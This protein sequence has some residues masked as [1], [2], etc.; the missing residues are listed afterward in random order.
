MTKRRWGDP[1]PLLFVQSDAYKGATRL[2]LN[3][4][5]ASGLLVIGAV[6]VRPCLPAL[7][8]M[9]VS[10]LRTGACASPIDVGSSTQNPRFASPF[11]RAGGR[12]W[13]R[14]PPEIGCPKDFLIQWLRT[15]KD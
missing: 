7:V 8:L 13:M 2:P 5:E 6:G 10:L 3:F 9:V 4:Y 1:R 11:N 12:S 14:N 15:D